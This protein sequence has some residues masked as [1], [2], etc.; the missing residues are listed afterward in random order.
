MNKILVIGLSGQSEF[1]NVNHFNHPGET[2]NALN[3]F[4]EPGGKGYNQALALGKLGSDVSFITCLG[5]DSYSEICIKVLKENNVKVYPIYKPTPCDFAC[6]MTDEQGENNVCV[7]NGASRLCTLSDIMKY[8]KV[9][10]EANII[11]LQLEYPLEVT[12]EII[13]YA[14]SKNILVILNP[15]PYK[16]L[17]NEILQNI[18]AIT[19]NEFELNGL[20]KSKDIYNCINSLNVKNIICTRGNKSILV[21]TPES[22]HEI[23]VMN[24]NAVDTTGAGDIFNAFFV[25]NLDKGIYNSAKIASIASSLSVLKKGV[26]NAIPS[27]DEVNKVWREE[28][29]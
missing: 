19:P 10:D 27:M 11:L 15:A 16:E 8:Q 7:Y 20:A 26:I 13:K 12:K 18:Y 24:V 2:I 28:N 21:K 23:K 4:T 22:L 29:E 3:R 14:N 1:L 25:H 6:I 17:D 9:I 5:I